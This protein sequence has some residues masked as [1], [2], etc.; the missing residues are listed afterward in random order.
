[1]STDLKTLYE[2]QPAAPSL[3]AVETSPITKGEWRCP[4]ITRIDLKRTLFGAGTIPDA[5]VGFP[6]TT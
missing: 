3:D 5:T 6:Q 1:M 2:S 4:V